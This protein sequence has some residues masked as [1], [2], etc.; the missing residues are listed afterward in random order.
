[1]RTAMIWGA[2]GGIG[3]AMISRLQKE[4][5]DIVAIGKDVD[6]IKGPVRL[7]IQA[8]MTDAVS[9]YDAILSVSYE[10]DE[11]AL[12]IYAVGD[13]VSDKVDTMGPDEW[14]RII[15]A[16]LTGAYLTTHYSLPLLAQD[17]YMIFLGA[18]SER[19]RLPGLSA[20]AA[21][22]SGIEA[23]VETLWKEQRKRRIMLVRPGAVRTPLWDKVPLNLPKNAATPEKIAARVIEA[24]F[25]GYTGVLDLT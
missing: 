23:F 5:W 20:Y 8:D 1:M 10:I 21:S 3:K 6:Q 15:A 18:V 17:A 9:V 2:N 22:K 19:L 4:E 11:I 25:K 16:N 24:S 14:N 13:I 12:S 7:A